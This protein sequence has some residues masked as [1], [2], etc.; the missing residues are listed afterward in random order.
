[1]HMEESN[2]LVLKKNVV[3]K[4]E[5]NIEYEILADNRIGI[6][7]ESQVY[8]ARRISD[9]EQFV[10]KIYD[11]FAEN[12]AKKKSN[13]KSVLDFLNKNSNN[14]KN[15]IMPLL[16]YGKIEMENHEGEYVSRPFDIIPYCKDGELKDCGYQVFEE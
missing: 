5:N 7:G 6:G 10:A 13:R 14:L 1:M 4:G 15:H 12:D 11:T 16:D 8:L 2:R 9:S 3:F